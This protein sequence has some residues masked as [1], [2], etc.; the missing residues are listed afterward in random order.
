MKDPLSTQKGS[1]FE[2]SGVS[3]GES[4]GP[5]SVSQ[6][7]VPGPGS[8]SDNQVNDPGSVSDNDDLGPNN[9]NNLPKK[10]YRYVLASCLGLF[11][12]SLFLSLMI[13]LPGNWVHIWKT[14]K[15]RILNIC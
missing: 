10:Y 14:T 11:K 5:S 6:E 3:H 4:P 13:S 1:N 12:H 9:D 8:S 15:R 7:N 2:S